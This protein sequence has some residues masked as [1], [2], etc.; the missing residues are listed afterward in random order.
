MLFLEQ[1]RGRPTWSLRATW[2]PRV[3]GQSFMGHSGHMDKLT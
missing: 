1:F 3:L 2:C